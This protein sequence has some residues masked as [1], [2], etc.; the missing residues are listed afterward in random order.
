MLTLLRPIAA[1]ERSAGK[2]YRSVREVAKRAYHPALFDAVDAALAL[3]PDDRPENF[4]G[5][6]Q[7]IERVRSNGGA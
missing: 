2:R 1:G 6:R 7:A 3:D 4:D 5:F